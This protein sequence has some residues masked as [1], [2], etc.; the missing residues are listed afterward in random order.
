VEWPFYCHF[1]YFYFSI[2]NHWVYLCFSKCLTGAVLLR[3]AVG[4][5]RFRAAFNR[6]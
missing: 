3:R 2:G 4:S 6:G 1:L 5:L